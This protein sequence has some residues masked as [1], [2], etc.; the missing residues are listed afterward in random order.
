[1]D[2]ETHIVDAYTPRE[3]ASKVERLGVA[4]ARTDGLT[5]LVLAILAGAFISLGALFFITVVTDANS[6]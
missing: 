6:R 3:I 4:K 5:L 2:Q 1:M